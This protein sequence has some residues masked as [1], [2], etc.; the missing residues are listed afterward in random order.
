MFL[1]RNALVYFYH[2]TARVKLTEPQD[3]GA[4]L[5]RLDEAA[6][7]GQGSLSW[8]NAGFPEIF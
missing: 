6:S 2:R 5:S 7:S 8:L 1:I 3:K 4:S